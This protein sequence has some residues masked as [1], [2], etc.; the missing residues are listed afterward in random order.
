MIESGG[1]KLPII[2]LKN[3]ARVFGAVLFQNAGVWRGTGPP[4]FVSVLVP[5]LPGRRFVVYQ[6]GPPQIVKSILQ[7]LLTQ[8]E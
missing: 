2:F 1:N 8:S 6:P 4:S 5:A 7:T 3:P